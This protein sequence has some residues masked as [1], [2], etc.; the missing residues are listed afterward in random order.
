MSKTSPSNVDDAG[1]ADAETKLEICAYQE[2]LQKMVFDAALTEERERRRIAIELHDRV[3]QALALAEIRLSTVRGDL[4]GEP[5]A[6]VDRA[7][8]L[9]GQAMTDMRVLTF[10]LSPPILYDLGLEHALAWLGESLE[11]DY[12]FKIDL[13]DDGAGQPLEEATRA[14]VFRAA[15]ELL[16]NVIKHARTGRASVSLTRTDQQLVIV[17]EDRGI[18]CDPRRVSER[19]AG[20]GLLSVREQ[21]RRLG[22]ML[23]VESAAE[24][25][26]RVSVR[27]PL[28]TSAAGQGQHRLES[29]SRG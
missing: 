24:R 1:R 23:D 3:G 28:R 26:T 25:G 11:K 2:K 4:T 29:P 12:G 16:M 10:E 15:R 17:V 13:H 8:D 5:R 9:L 19:A 6:A 21:V 7:V 27:V 14:L 20:F 18:G 22:G